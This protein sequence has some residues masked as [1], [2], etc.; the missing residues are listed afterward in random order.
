M[1]YVWTFRNR[2]SS[3]IIV[4]IKMNRSCIKISHRWNFTKHWSSRLST[5]KTRWS[6]IFSPCRF[7][8]HFIPI[9]T[10]QIEF[11]FGFQ[12]SLISYPKT[13]DSFGQLFTL[14]LIGNVMDGSKIVYNNQPIEV[15]LE[16]CKQSIST[17]GE[18]VWYSCE[19]NRRFS[20]E[21]G[22]EDLE[23]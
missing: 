13:N 18:P 11:F 19:V 3:G 1:A 5:S 12:V 20:N 23:M 14:D 10:F 17:L 22:C 21:L 2:P 9:T 15:L 4:S 16:A 6:W 8:D 7:A